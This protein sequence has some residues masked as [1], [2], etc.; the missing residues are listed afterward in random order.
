MISPVLKEQI[1]TH[2]SYLDED[3]ELQS[4]TR[5]TVNNPRCSTST[6]GTGTTQLNVWRD[7]AEAQEVVQISAGGVSVRNR[8]MLLELIAWN[9]QYFNKNRVI[10]VN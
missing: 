2:T 5:P 4:A 6:D 1:W 10:I 3:R 8:V 7:A 9:Y